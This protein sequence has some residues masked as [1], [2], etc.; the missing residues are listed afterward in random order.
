MTKL[1]KFNFNNLTQEEKVLNY[2]MDGNEITNDKAMSLFQIRRLSA[3][4]YA[5]KRQGLDVRKEWR[6]SYTQARY[7][8]Y[9]MPCR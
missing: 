8:V 5:L 7:S 4:I 6:K 1:H 3:V 9:Y 2:L